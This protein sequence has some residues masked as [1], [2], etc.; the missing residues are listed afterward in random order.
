MPR[1]IVP[2]LLTLL[3]AAPAASLIAQQPSQP[4]TSAPSAPAPLANAT[5]GPRLQ[6]NFPS[7]QPALGHEAAAAAAADRTVITISTLGLILLVVLLI[8]LIS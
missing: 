4:A 1:R 7:Y 6:Q 3:C 5:A 8:I 2:L